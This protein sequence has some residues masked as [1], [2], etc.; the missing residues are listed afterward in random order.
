M[1][2]YGVLNE[3]FNLG[4]MSYDDV[5]LNCLKISE[6]IKEV[7]DKEID[8]YVKK[9]VIRSVMDSLV[10]LAFVGFVIGVLNLAQ[11][12]V[13]GVFIPV[14]IIISIYISYLIL[15]NQIRKAEIKY[16]Q[17][18]DYQKSLRDIQ[19]NLIKKADILSSNK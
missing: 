12:T 10:P 4:D 16:S 2:K 17:I 14:Y 9:E 8:F 18:R 13:K 5:L 1:K 15:N 6:R 3:G 7:S 19:V 11:G